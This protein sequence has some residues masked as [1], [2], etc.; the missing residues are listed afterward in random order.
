MFLRMELSKPSI[1]EYY[2]LLR[3][4]QKSLLECK[5]EIS[6]LRRLRHKSNDPETIAK[7]DEKLEKLTDIRIYLE[8]II[9][10]A[11]KCRHQGHLDEALEVL[12][13]V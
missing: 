7:I 11:R 5:S 12:K 6:H 9:S 10:Y 8:N 2:T 1:E 4:V 13:E 3:K